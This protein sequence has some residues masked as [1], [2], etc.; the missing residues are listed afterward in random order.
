VSPCL[1]LHVRLRGHNCEAWPSISRG[2]VCSV[3]ELASYLLLSGSGTRAC[4][5][6]TSLQHWRPSC[7][8]AQAQAIGSE[9][10]RAAATRLRR[11]CTGGCPCVLWPWPQ[12]LSSQEAGEVVMCFKLMPWQL[13]G[14]WWSWWCYWRLQKQAANCVCIV[15]VR[16][17][18]RTRGECQ[19]VS[20]LNGVQIQRKVYGACEQ[21]QEVSSYIGLGTV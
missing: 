4:E 2:A 7:M 11:R 21:S 5:R 1:C 9:C 13:L 19:S 10:R 16:V 17:R 14:C 3:C 12:R 18:A 6:N 15:C 20:S 8:V